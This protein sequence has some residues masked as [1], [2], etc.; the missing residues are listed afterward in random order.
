MKLTRLFKRC[1]EFKLAITLT[2]LLACNTSVDDEV[3]EVTP[4]Q[5]RIGILAPI[6]GPLAGFGLDMVS[7][8]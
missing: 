1:I 5:I 7:T 4:E 8:A 3:V 6:T 2:F